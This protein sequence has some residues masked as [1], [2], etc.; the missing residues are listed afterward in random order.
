MIGSD[1]AGEGIGFD[2][3][4]VRNAGVIYLEMTNIDLAESARPLAPSFTGPLALARVIDS[5]GASCIDPLPL[6]TGRMRGRLRPAPSAHFGRASFCGCRGAADQQ[7]GP[8]SN[9]RA[10]A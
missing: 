4:S 6:V 9:W 10:Q 7:C 5:N 2:F 8:C 3:R 1:G